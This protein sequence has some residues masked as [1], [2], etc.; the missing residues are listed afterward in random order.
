MERA[1]A[2]LTDDDRA[3]FKGRNFGHVATVMPDGSP[4]VSPV[5]IDIEDDTDL[6]LVNTAL[7]RVKT[8]N[9][10]RDP[11]VAISVVD[12]ED[13]YTMVAVRGRVVEVTREGAED[14]IDF[15]SRKYGGRDYPD[16][17]DRV[18][19]KIA[20]THVGRM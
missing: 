2:R 17:G 20:A 11:H 6:I 10:E 15:L 3:L 7:G 8:R 4:Q 12:S 13:P 18:L 19:F 1:A 5:W 9:M 14:H 16:H